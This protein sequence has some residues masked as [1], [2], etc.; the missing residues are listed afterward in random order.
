MVDV[1]SRKIT[2]SE[3]HETV[4]STLAAELLQYGVMAECCAS[5]LK[6]LHADNGAIQKSS[7][8]RKKMEWLGSGV[9]HLYTG[10][11]SSTNTAALSLSHLGKDTAVMIFKYWHN[12]MS[13]IVHQRMQTL[14][15]GAVKHVTGY[16][17]ER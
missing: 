11:T 10:T 4:C 8:L 16:T 5:T 7:T 15:V 2:A 12:M 17:Q 1:F 14:V 9:P 3:V 6:Y 13:Y